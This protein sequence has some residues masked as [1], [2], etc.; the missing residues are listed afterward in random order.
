MTAAA[1]TSL[2]LAFANEPYV[3][4][5][6]NACV[7]IEQKLGSLGKAGSSYKGVCIL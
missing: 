3:C 1:E 5:F 6:P 2:V 4:G 7:K